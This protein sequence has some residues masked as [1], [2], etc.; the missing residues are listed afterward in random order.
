[1]GSY[2]GDGL[3]LFVVDEGAG[4]DFQL[5]QVGRHVL[6]TVVVGL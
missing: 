1:M 6:G 5:P 4:Q 2:R 3:V